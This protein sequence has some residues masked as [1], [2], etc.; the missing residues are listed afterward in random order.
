MNSPTDNQQP[1][2]PP[3]NVGLTDLLGVSSFDATQAARTFESQPF[4]AAGYQSARI[5]KCKDISNQVLFGFLR[6]IGVTENVELLSRVEVDM[7]FGNTGVVMH[8]LTGYSEI[9]PTFR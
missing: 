9:S 2:T 7:D 6:A 5:M 8:R 3:K 4:E 1:E